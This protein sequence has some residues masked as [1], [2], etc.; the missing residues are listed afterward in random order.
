MLHPR[1]VAALVRLLIVIQRASADAAGWEEVSRLFVG[2]SESFTGDR[3]AALRA[4][5]EWIDDDA[6]TRDT[7]N[8]SAFCRLPAP[9][10]NGDAVDALR[11]IVAPAVIEAVRGGTSHQLSVAAEARLDLCLEHCTQGMMTFAADGQCL[12]VNRTAVRLLKL[13]VEPH[14][15]LINRRILQRPLRT[16]VDEFVAGTNAKADWLAPRT[17][18][19]SDSR[20]QCFPLV[21]AKPGERG[22]ESLLHLFLLGEAKSDDLT[23]RLLRRAHLSKQETF[24]V[25][26]IFDGKSSATIA[27][28]MKLSVHTVRTYVDR[29]YQKLDVSNRYELMKLVNSVADYPA[30]DDDGG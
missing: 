1:D 18:E 29:V 27:H 22:P 26:A 6:S 13:P 25:R 23:E 19:I 3:L 4:V 9:R 11:E 28:D 10:S 8:D 2:L 30:I 14:G 7:S 17:L 15:A 20:V 21:V 16:L 12:Y 24:V 5:R